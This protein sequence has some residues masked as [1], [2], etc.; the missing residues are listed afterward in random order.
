VPAGSLLFILEGVAPP[1]GYS[2]VGTFVQER[3]DPDGPGGQPPERINVV[4]W[5]KQ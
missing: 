4:M 3:V 2:L 1:P 5:R